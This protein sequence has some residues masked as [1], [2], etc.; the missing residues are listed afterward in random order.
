MRKT[1]PGIDRITIASLRRL[2]SYTDNEMTRH[3]VHCIQCSDAGKDVMAWC[4]KWWQ[5]ARTLHRT[6]RKLKRLD[7]LI[8]A[9]QE[10]LPGL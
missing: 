8:N 3:T 2:A 1:T 4:G 7:T 10:T 6:R 5:L 9:A